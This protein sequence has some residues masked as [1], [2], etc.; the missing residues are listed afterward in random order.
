MSSDQEVLYWENEIFKT[1][2]VVPLDLPA[3]LSKAS[4]VVQDETQMH[5]LKEN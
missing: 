1:P 3:L 2:V 4:V 5:L